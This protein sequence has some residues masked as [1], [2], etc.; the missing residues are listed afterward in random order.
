MPCSRT[1]SL[2]LKSNRSRWPHRKSFCCGLASVIFFESANPGPDTRR[3]G[4]STNVWRVN[5]NR[6]A[7]IAFTGVLNDASS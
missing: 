7:F 1:P 4:N 3:S 6:S 2:F 5:R